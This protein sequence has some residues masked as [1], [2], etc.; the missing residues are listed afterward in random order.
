VTSFDAIS[1]GSATGNSAVFWARAKAPG[2]A[3]LV[4]G[5]AE[6]G[7][8]RKYRTIVAVTSDAAADNTV[9]QLVSGLQTGTRYS[10]RFSGND[11]VTSPF[12]SIKTA[13]ARDAVT[14][15]RFGFSG[16]ASARYAPFNAMADVAVQDLDFFVMLGDAAYEDSF[17]YR[18]GS[19]SRE[20]LPPFNTAN[21]S[22]PSATAIATAMAAMGSKYRD[23]LDPA[24][25]NLA[26]LYR[27]QGVLSS[28]DNHEM[29]DMALETGGA[30]RSAVRSFTDDDGDKA[31]REG[32]DFNPTN[33]D[34]TIFNRSRDFLNKS[35]EH[36]AMVDT[37]LRYMPIATPELHK[38]P[39]DPRTDGTYKLYGA[40]QWGKHAVFLT[41]DNRSYRDAKA[42]QLKPDGQGSDESDYTGTDRDG[43]QI[44]MAQVTA[45]VDAERRTILGDT[46]FTWLKQTLLEAQRAGTTWKF[47]SLSSPIDITG[48]VS[49][50]KDNNAVNKGATW[51]DNKSWW[52]ASPNERN[53]LLQYIDDNDISNV[54][55]ISTDDHEARI[56]ELTYAPTGVAL[57][58]LINYRRVPGAISIVASPIGAVRPDAF[59]SNDLVT[60]SQTL[61]RNYRERHLD[62]IGLSA[63]YPGLVA[64]KRQA[65]GNHT[66]ADVNNPQPIDF[67]SPNTFNYAVLD[68]NA[69]GQLTVSL[70]G[71]A[72]S[73]ANTGSTWQPIGSPDAVDEILSFTLNPLA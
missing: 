10:Y 19:R 7:L 72:A 30:P 36:R 47:V 13:P 17:T 64:L 28:F 51:I 67:W 12:G 26:P 60:T 6:Y 1:A 21:P 50:G 61:A 62:P 54:V 35:P 43:K 58:D 31:L 59:L 8:R 66:Q 68:V 63:G 70:R 37:W 45:A 49:D 52:G 38:T 20:A 44:T 57:D 16:C 9:K 18:D 14:G 25:G 39:N 24:V 29:V 42:T 55:F 69:G 5:E 53:A 71:L 48:L 56:N 11:L 15:V 2:A 73:K 22:T 4:Y 40:Q 41:V 46:Q 3:Q 23:N 65:I 34:N 32:V 27:A 33:S